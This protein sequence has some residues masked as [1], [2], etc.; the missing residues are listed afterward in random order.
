MQD[1]PQRNWYLIHAVG[2]RT[3]VNSVD[4]RVKPNDG[5]NFAADSRG[6]QLDHGDISEP[7]L[8]WFGESGYSFS[9]DEHKAIGFS[10]REHRTGG[11]FAGT[12]SRVASRQVDTKWITGLPAQYT[13]CAGHIARNSHAANDESR[14]QVE[15][16]YQ[17]EQGF[18]RTMSGGAIG[19]LYAEENCTVVAVPEFVREFPQDRQR[20][21]T[22]GAVGYLNIRNQP[23]QD[24]QYFEVAAGFNADELV[25]C[26]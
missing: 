13:V 26:G 22:I 21:T 16:G 25:S 4:R 20:N 3:A 19:E 18:D 1:L 6:I 5:G 17:S 7:G 8:G 23:T 12:V 2:R 15:V 11:I 14:V 24:P 9:T 10:A